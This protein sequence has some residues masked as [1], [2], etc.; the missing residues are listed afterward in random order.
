MRILVTD[1][2]LLALEDTYEAVLSALPDAEVVPCE[3]VFDAL[4]EAKEPFDI[5]FLDVEM[6]GMTGIELARKLQE[7]YPKIN[8]VFITAYPQYALEAYDILASSYCVKPITIEAIKKAIDNLRYS[9][10]DPRVI[11]KLKSGKLKV[12]CF[13]EFMI[14]DGNNEPVVMRREKSKELFAYLVSKNGAD[15]SP[16]EM[17]DALWGEDSDNKL[18]YFW[19]LTSELRKSLADVGAGDVLRQ[20]RGRYAINKDKIECD[21]YQYQDKTYRNAW[22]GKF[23][24][25]YGGWAEVVKASLINKR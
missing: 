19:K 23:C 21:Y 17:C 3:T 10:D 8:I 6:P 15:A 20:G 1:D 4:N 11:N 22:N 14:Y 7:K 12:K 9:L 13:G 5:A 18:D 25:Q 24:E 16:T 2:E